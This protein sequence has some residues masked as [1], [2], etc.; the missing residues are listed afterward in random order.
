MAFA[1]AA[2]AARGAPSAFVQCASPNVNAH[3]LLCMYLAFRQARLVPERLVLAFTYDDLKE[4][5]LRPAAL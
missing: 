3:E 1:Q 5:G 2:A 4:P